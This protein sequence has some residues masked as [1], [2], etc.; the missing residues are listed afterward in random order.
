VAAPIPPPPAAPVAPVGG[1]RPNPQIAQ[2]K[3]TLYFFSR[4]T[5]AVVGLAVIIFFILVAIGGLFYPAPNL[6]LQDYCGTTTSSGEQNASLVATT[7]PGPVI[8]TYPNTAPPPG[9]NCYPV[10]Q[11]SPSLVG[12]TVDLSHFKLGALPFGS[13][14]VD[15]GGS[16]FFNPFAG[17]IK[18]AQWS[19][20][21]AFGIVL[22]GAMIGLLL[23]A[24]AGYFGGIVDEVVMRLTDIFLSIPGFLLVLVIIA[25]V[26]ATIS[27][28][29]GRILVLMGAFIVTWWPL[30]TRIVR[31][32]VLVT[33]EQ[34]FVEA[35]KA[36]GARSGRMILRHIIP[37][38]M[39]PIFVQMSLDV[40]AIPLALGGIIFLGFQIFPTE[41]FPEWGTIAAL[42]VNIIP[43]ELVLCSGGTCIF[44]WWQILFPGLTLFLFAISV[45]FLSDG[46]RDALDPRLR[47]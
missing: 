22:S 43:S 36:S 32:Q 3:R 41:Y 21:I 19:M 47:R 11:F 42:S 12:P 31:G 2:L 18:G 33:R 24:T 23:G 26:G 27:S 20:A 40:G 13:L 5:L 37:N 46:L 7:C 25:S 38:S 4:S 15:A 9:P 35:S 16:L 44:P 1:R 17:L 45:N 28:L 8:C 10:D 6:A 30:Y 29:D 39:Y 34:K 14:S